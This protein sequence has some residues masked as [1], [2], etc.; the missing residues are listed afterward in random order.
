MQADTKLLPV[1]Q[2]AVYSSGAQEVQMQIAVRVNTLHFLNNTI[3]YSFHFCLHDFRY[4]YC[5]PLLIKLMFSL[6]AV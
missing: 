5:D 6:S 4:L 1:N 2:G 3:I